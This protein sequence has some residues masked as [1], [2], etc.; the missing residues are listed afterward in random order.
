[1]SWYPRQPTAGRAGAGGSPRRTGRQRP[2]RRPAAVPAAGPSRGRRPAFVPSTPSPRHLGTCASGRW[3]RP[4][5][6]TSG[7]RLRFR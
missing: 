2:T 6:A 4:G 3:R 7:W 5:Q 1:M